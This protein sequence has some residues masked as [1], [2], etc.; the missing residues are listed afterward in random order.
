MT[1]IDLNTIA[2]TLLESTDGERNRFLPPDLRTVKQI[3]H[4]IRTLLLPEYYMSGEDD[5]E[6]YKALLFT[7]YHNLK[8]QVRA[9]YQFSGLSD[10]PATEVC[11]ALFAA[12]PELQRLL[13]LDL[14]AGFDGDPAAKS[15]G[16]V[17][18][19]YPGFFAISTYRIAHELYEAGVPY[20][21]R[22]M[23]EYAHN[24][25][26]IDINPGAKIGESF[27]IDHGTGIVIGETT[28]IGNNVKVYQGVTLGALST[29]GGQR[30][31]GKKRHPTVEDNVTIY[32]GATIL[33]GET[34]L[35]RNSTIGGCT[36][37]TESVPADTVYRVK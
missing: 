20:L 37:I 31:S 23:T 5:T 19:S 11:D 4:D 16:E 2:N 28:E 22:M 21:P 8:R 6:A 14:I 30:L 10:E 27:F 12:F 13:R 1:E 35:G 24:K 3:I 25:T 15:Y 32:A 18:L 29:R 33:G 17:A 9:A 26:G 36:F 34:V 7:T